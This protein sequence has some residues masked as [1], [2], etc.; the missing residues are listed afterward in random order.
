MAPRRG[1]P[2]HAGMGLGGTLLCAIDVDRRAPGLVACARQWAAATGLR[3]RFVHARAA[4]GA[5]GRA[6]RLLRG[7]GLAEDELRIVTGGP[8]VAVLELV[9][10]EEPALV[11]VASS[12]DDDG[13]LGSLCTALLRGAPRPVA[14]LPPDGEASFSGGPIACAVSVGHGDEAAVRFAGA[15][16]SASG[17]RLALMHVVGAKDAARLA[18]ARM[19]GSPSRSPA[20]GLGPRPLAQRLVEVARDSEADALVVASRPQDAA[21]DGLLSS[22][23]RRLWTAA[24]C[25][26]VVVHA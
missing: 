26:V 10:A 2:Q 8:A 18:A 19:G 9:R 14:V 13:R 3:A 23:A 15:L 24:P 22:V 11:L 7:L 20:A 5:D 4:P 1:G 6:Q 16:A 17:R 25:P 12:A 21:A